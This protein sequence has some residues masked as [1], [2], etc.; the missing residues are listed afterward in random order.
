MTLRLVKMNAPAPDEAD[1]EA[2][3]PARDWFTT[4]EL[5]G[6]AL[7]GLAGDKR[8][9]NRRAKDE[10]WHLRAGADGEPL[11][12]RRSGRGGGVEYHVSLLPA[13]A[14]LALVTRGL[15]AEVPVAGLGSAEALSAGRWAWYDAQNART[16]AKAEERMALIAEIELLESAGMTRTAAV[17]QVSKRHGTGAST[18]YAWLSLIDGVAYHDRLPAIAPRFVGGGKAADIDPAIWEVFKSDYMRLSEPPLSVCY[19]K[20]AALAEARGLS[21]PS[22]KA[23]KRRFEQEVPQA[24]R[25]LARKGSE[26]LRRSLPAIRRTVDELHALQLVNMD[27][28]R[29]DVFVTPPE[30]GKPV[31]P[32][33]IG[34][35]DVHSRKLLA[36]RIGSTESAG[37]TRLV[38]SDLFANFGVPLEVYLDN[39][40]A[41][42][43][44]WISGGAATRYRYKISAEEPSGLLTGLGVKVHFTLPYRGQ[45]KPIE[46]AWR[47]LCDFVSKGALCDGAYTG[48]NTVNKPDNYG[49]R[50]VPWAEF[51]DEVGRMINLH[52]ALTG[53]RGGV[54]RGRSFDEVFTESFATAPIGRATPE[55]MRKALLTASAIKV[56]RQT[57]EIGLYGNR[58]YAPFC[59]DLHGERVIVRFDPDAL[60][61]SV[62]VYGLDD[63]Y[64]GEAHLWADAGFADVDGAKRT[65][66]LA[67]DHKQAV[68][69]LVEAHRL[70]DA[71]EVAVIQRE[72]GG[73]APELPEPKVI[74]PVRHRGQTA[75]ALKLAD[76]PEAAPREPQESRVFGALRLLPDPE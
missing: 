38:F 39:G 12:R 28:H 9:L 41:F 64:L 60:H 56:N 1:G 76:A 47:S 49:K 52:N 36:W 63:R 6:L 29:F 54:C 68:R 61:Q 70:L 66:K 57:G 3:A 13:P 14:R 5:A 53:R 27:G 43:S 45:S 22:E 46:R 72:I 74:R 32:I 11:S 40:M 21:V 73:A 8:S 23:F 37:M 4:A 16:K 18:L 65:A 17:A 30:G 20:A 44:K 15:I 24:A 42:A 50:A 55:V 69:A 58:Y 19:A 62:H 51:A 10:R 26:A 33:L 59:S 35:Q 75:A 71:A 34:I 25:L 7:D 67:A 2:P 31:R 48:N